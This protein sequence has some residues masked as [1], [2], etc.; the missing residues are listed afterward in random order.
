[1]VHGSNPM[2]TKETY[3]TQQNKTLKQKHKM[4][5][6]GHVSGRRVETKKNKAVKSNGINKHRVQRERERK[7]NQIGLCNYI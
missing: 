7:K 2:D 5:F 1:M 6:L 4:F 3:T